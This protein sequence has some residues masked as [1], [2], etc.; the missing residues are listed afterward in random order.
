MTGWSCSDCGFELYYP[1]STELS[2]CVV[3]LYDDARFPGRALVVNRDH[4]TRLEDLSDTEY[5]NFWLDV[6][7]TLGAL[8]VATGGVRINVAVLGNAVPHLHAHL[9]PRYPE[10]EFLPTRPPWNDPRDLIQLDPK[11]LAGLQMQIS[12]L[13]SR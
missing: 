10:T 13:L 3:G 7:M 6:K 5:V 8:R 1:V 9:I 4:R 2:T 11:T 12:E